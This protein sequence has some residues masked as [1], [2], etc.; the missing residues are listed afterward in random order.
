M[1][2][3]E[4]PVHLNHQLQEWIPWGC[5]KSA[6]ANVMVKSGDL[7]EP[8]V[9]FPHALKGADMEDAVI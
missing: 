9:V 4:H 7:G 8:V 1:P 2:G 5:N 6:N 3:G